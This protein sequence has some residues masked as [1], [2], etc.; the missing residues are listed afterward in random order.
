MNV[1]Y[2]MLRTHKVLSITHG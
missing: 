2:L 1:V